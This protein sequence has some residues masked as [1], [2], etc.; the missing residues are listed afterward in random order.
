ME[1]EQNV[2][3]AY[4]EG[5]KDLRKT[6]IDDIL[7]GVVLCFF[8]IA[9]YFLASTNHKCLEK[10]Y[11]NPSKIIQNSSQ[12]NQNDAQERSRKRPWRKV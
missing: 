12:I 3:K 9:L 1:A 11:L 2:M 7:I 8:A 5:D 4:W 10:V 6:L